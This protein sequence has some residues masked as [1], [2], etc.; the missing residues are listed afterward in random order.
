MSDNP[1]IVVE[2]KNDARGA[3]P[4]GAQEG[5]R[6]CEKDVAGGD[7]ASS[8]RERGSDRIPDERGDLEHVRIG[9]RAG[10]RLKGS[11]VPGPLARI[12]IGRSL[13]ARENRHVTG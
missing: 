4:L 8:L 9:D 10:A 6:L 7:P 11:A 2:E 3:E 13:F 1:A 12:V 5:I